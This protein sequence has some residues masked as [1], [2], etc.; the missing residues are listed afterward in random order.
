MDGQDDK[1]D[2]RLWKRNWGQNEVYNIINYA[3]TISHILKYFNL[4]FLVLRGNFLILMSVEKNP[5]KNDDFLVV[6]ADKN[7]SSR[8]Q[9]NEGKHFFI[10][11]MGN[12]FPNM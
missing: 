4:S 10:V 5:M 6:R 1:L 3:P 9:D 2:K 12:A 7:V 11:I 8:I